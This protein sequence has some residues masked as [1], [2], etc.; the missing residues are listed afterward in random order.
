MTEIT[1]SQWAI[2]ELMGHKVVAGLVSKDEML[3]APMLRIDVPATSAFPQFTQLYGQAAVYCV[4]FTS[5]EIARKTAE[6]TAVNPVAVY[7]PTLVTREQH[8]AVVSELKRRTETLREE[9]YRLRHSLPSPSDTEDDDE[10][11]EP[12]ADEEDDE[13]DEEQV[14]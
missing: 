10:D 3:G 9:L 2:V 4:T 11:D 5:E 6:A 8:D 14:F 13:E 1:N 7:V 12:Y